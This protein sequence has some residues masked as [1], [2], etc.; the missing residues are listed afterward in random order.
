VLQLNGISRRKF[1][2][3]S[4]KK[5]NVTQRRQEHQAWT[6][7]KDFSFAIFAPL[8]ENVFDICSN[9]FK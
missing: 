5:I 6:E 3:L 2:K 4:Q 9:Y 7:L 8:R 1:W